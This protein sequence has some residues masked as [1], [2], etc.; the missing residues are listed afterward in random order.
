M[1]N[2]VDEEIEVLS[3]KVPYFASLGRPLLIGRDGD[4]VAAKTR[5]AVAILGFLSRVSDMSASRE[6]LADMLWSSAVRQ[7]GMQSL[8]QALKQLKTA[9]NEA[10]LDAVISTSGHIQLDQYVLRTD[11]RH[12]EVLVNQ[13][14]SV[15][16]ETAQ[17]LW[18]G[19]FL[20]G[21]DDLDPQFS[22]WLQVER[23]RIKAEIVGATLKHLTALAIDRGAP[24]VEPAA[25]FLLHIDPAFEPA[26]RAL[27]RFFVK[28]G[29]HDR[30]EQ[31]YL[32]CEREL[33]ELDLV[34]DAETREFLDFAG[35]TGVQLP[36][37]ISPTVEIDA[38]EWNTESEGLQLGRG[39]GDDAVLLPSVSIITGGLSQT[40]NPIGQDIEEEVIAGLSSYRNFDLYQSDY[41]TEDHGPN[42]SLLQ[43]DELGSYLLRFQHN[44]RSGKTSIQFEDRTDGRIVFNEIVDPSMWDNVQ[45]AAGQIVNRIQL[46]ADTKLR[47]PKNSAVFAKW[48][49]AESLM[50]DFDPRSDKKALE[51]LAQIEREHPSFSRIY[52]GRA[53]INLKQL[54][55]YAI[56]DRQKWLALDEIRTLTERAVALDPWLPINQRAHGWALIQSRLADDAR[57]AFLQAARLNTVDPVNMISVAEGLAFSGDVEKARDNAEKALQL[58]SSVP[59]FFYE[60]ISHVYFAAEDFEGAQRMIEKTATSSLTGLTTRVAALICSG[61]EDQALAMLKLHGETYANRILSKGPDEWEYRLNFFTEPKARANYEKGVQMVKRFF[62]GDR[63]SVS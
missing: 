4:P 14:D 11:I 45:A 46:F 26:H 5:K 62:F 27:I 29:Q 49:Q 2:G 38:S 24:Q 17:G 23:E 20:R 37:A 18:R 25:N 61:K 40:Q 7:K 15:S 28:H 1:K 34:P 21:F 60:Y 57:R 43:A 41:F 6:L 53:L 39:F 52:S 56:D 58:S 13:G 51:L 42:L 19:E 30:A 59:R 9:E 48:C 8:R 3:I 10:G 16:F 63:A 22:E 31:Q 35:A 36:T 44:E 54:V 32:A 33:K 50:L 12:V 55:Y 47:N